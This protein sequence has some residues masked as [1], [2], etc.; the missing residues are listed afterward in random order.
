MRTKDGS[1]RMCIGY[2][3]LNKAMVNTM[4]PILRIDNLFDQLQGAKF[5]SKIDL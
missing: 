2:Q 1:L 4:Y 5:F 3:Q